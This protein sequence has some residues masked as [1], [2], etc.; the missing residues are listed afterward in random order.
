MSDAIAIIGN[1]NCGKTTLFNALTGTYQK[2]G[3]WTGVTTEKKEG[4]YKKD[5]TVKL[6]DLP[7]IYSF[8]AKSEDERAVISYL[9][10]SPPKVVINIV[11]GTNLERN[12]YLTCELALLKIPT[13]IAVNMYDQLQ[14]N[15]IK[16]NEEKLSEMFGV[17]VVPISAVKGTNLDKLIEIARAAN[18]PLKALKLTDIQAT[19][20]Q[21]K[22]YAFLENNLKDIIQ[23]K[24]TKA[25]R[26]T[27]RIDNLLTHPIWGV[28]I[29]FLVITLVYYLS[30]TLGGGL[31]SYVSN[32]FNE[33]GGVISRFLKVHAV[34]EWIEGLT[35]NA[36]L[37]GAGTVFSFLPQILILFALMAVIE[38]SG[39]ASRIAFIFHRFFRCLGLNGKSLMPLIVSCGC[40]VTGLMATRTIESKSERRMTIFLCP[41]MPCGAKMVVFGW[42][43]SIVFGGNALIASSMYFLSIF[44]VAFFG[45]LLKRL[46]VFSLDE[47]L[48]IL[49]IPCLRFPTVKDVFF[50]LWEKVKEFIV[51]AGMIVFLVSVILW[52]LQN[53]GA[54]GYVYGN[55]ENSFLYSIGNVLKYV[56]YPLGFGNWQASV[57][58]VSGLLAK[59]A[60]VETL[61]VV[62]QD[63]NSIFSSGWSAYAFMVF[64]LL[65]PPCIAS[66]SSASKELG[67]KKWLIFMIL[68]QFVAGYAVAFIINL[69]GIL[70]ECATGLILSL[71]IVIIITLI[72]VGFIKRLNLSGCKHCGLCGRKR[73]CRNQNQCMIE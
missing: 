33:T 31:G 64:V 50:V 18:K 57:A 41:F 7:G 42:F 43:S 48:F 23:Q 34:P 63:A 35:C 62:S 56:F 3:N 30:I 73:K 6:V 8:D 45:R 52:A 38:E 66:I 39:Y 40:T 59:E 25:Q 24:E 53:L 67:S 70:I 44:S 60:V 2:T 32:L 4:R 65:S 29:F 26:L 69:I 20:I 5:K 68:F 28:P 37:G 12:L 49:E 51:K 17:P 36:I 16:L 19:S 13:V 21:G 71:I 47:S 55:V 54:T 27:E 72:S 22:R 15:G 14:K 46:K 10:K 9:K 1:P 11:D 61:C 58:V